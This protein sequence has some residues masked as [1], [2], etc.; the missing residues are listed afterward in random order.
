MDLNKNNNLGLIILALSIVVSSI[1]ISNNQSSGISNP[2]IEQNHKISGEINGYQI[3]LQIT[4][5]SNDVTFKTETKLNGPSK[6]EIILS[7]GKIEVIQA[8][9]ITTNFYHVSKFL[10]VEYKLD[11]ITPDLPTLV[12]QIKLINH[13]CICNFF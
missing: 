3:P 7:N 13:S 10:V 6:L 8:N 2:N 12:Q 5:N 9:D 4:S 11:N 1:I